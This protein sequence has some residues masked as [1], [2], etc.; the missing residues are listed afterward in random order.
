MAAGWTLQRSLDYTRWLATSHYENFHLVSFLLPRRLRQDF[1][2]VY[3][4]CRWSDDLA[5]ESGSPSRSI[6]LL[7]WWRSLLR[8][9]CSGRAPAHPVFVA[10]QSTIER[11]SLP[12]KPFD[13]LLNA[14]VRDQ[15]QTRYRDWPGLFAY[16]ENS[17]NPVG[18][19]VL[20]LCGYR[21]E[22]RF[23][24]SDF[25]CTALQLANFWQDVSIDLQK[26]R[27]YLPLQLLEKHNYSVERL[28]D[29]DASPE[30]RAVMREAVGVAADLFSKG[31][32]L[33]STLDRRLALD[34]DLFSR[35][36]MKVLDKIRALNYDVLA[37]RPA[38]TKS[39][40][41]ALLLRSLLRTTLA[42]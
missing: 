42:A 14:F 6:E 41:V 21:D 30:F 27:V 34:I 7:H 19:L 29:G 20:M 15:T 36:G 9:T 3:A 38:I 32:P 28:K 33:V 35:G 37:R 5:D 40:R 24:L 8:Q 25:T 39:E 26:D 4:Y 10:L 17:A 2:N 22:Q 11:H 31:L 12:E 13:D 18:R 16:C 23:Q 1:F